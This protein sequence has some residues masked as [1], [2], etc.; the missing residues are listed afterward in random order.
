VLSIDC[1]V[2]LYLHIFRNPA[3]RFL[4]GFAACHGFGQRLAEFAMTSVQ[5]RAQR[6]AEEIEAEFSPDSSES[7]YI[8]QKI[9]CKNISV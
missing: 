9:F 7:F 3:K 5:E 4:V 8:F 1:E 2:S 6:D